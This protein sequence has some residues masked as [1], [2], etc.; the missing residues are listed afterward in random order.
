MI[1]GSS[2]R[3]PAHPIDPLFLDRWSPRAM[4]GETVSESELMVL[5]EAAR[6]APSSMNFQPWRM[7]YTLR[8]TASWPVFLDLLV[9]A[10]RAWAQHAGAMVLFASRK[11]F[12][13]NAGPCRTH[14]FDTG[15]AWQN[16]ALQGWLSKLAVHGI[17]G[18]DYERARSVLRIPEEYSIEAMAIVGRPGDTS[19]LPE[20]YQG[21][22]HPN[23]RRPLSDTAREGLF[24]FQV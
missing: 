12:D 19:N 8:G 23:D 16:F 15:A 21:R 6:W 22:E 11:L 1:K 18:F 9:D 24:S 14:A 13:G 3:R 17:Q 4:S 20:R 5:L 2:V 10:N 7:V